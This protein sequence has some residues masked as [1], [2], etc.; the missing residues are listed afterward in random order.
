MTSDTDLP[1]SVAEHAAYWWLTVNDEDC[2]GR[3]Q[4]AFASWAAQSPERI[5]AYLRTAMVAKAS[6]SHDVR[7]PEMSTAALVRE[8]KSAVGQG[9][10]VSHESWRR[11]SPV[12]R[13]INF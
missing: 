9:S 10:Q 8:A 5:A 3:E 13:V 4:R 7:W 1:A 2:S 6:R 11:P 12:S